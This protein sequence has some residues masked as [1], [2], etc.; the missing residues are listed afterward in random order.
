M[1]STS[2]TV[3]GKE[4]LQAVVEQSQWATRPSRHKAGHQRVER[5]ILTGGERVPRDAA[6]AERIRGW[7]C[8]WK[9]K[10]KS[11]NSA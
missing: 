5:E 1:F 11:S 4:L 9:N 3:E 8:I 10:W 7:N 2:V 6:R